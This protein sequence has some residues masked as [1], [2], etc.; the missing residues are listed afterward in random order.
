MNINFFN[1]KPEVEID[2]EEQ[3]RIKLLEIGLCL[4]E[5]RQNKQLTKEM[6]SNQIHVPIRLLEA[7]ESANL[8]ELP[9]PIYT[10]EL[11]R[12][13]AN[14][15]GLK[16]DD[17]ANDF[18]IE[19]H[20]NK[21]PKYYRKF[22]VNISLLKLN[23]FSLYLIYIILVFIS[24]KNLAN[25][26]KNSPSTNYNSNYNSNKIEIIEK[27]VISSKSSKNNSTPIAIPAVKN[28]LTDNIKTTKIKFEPEKIIIDVTAEDE[29]WIKITIDGKQEFKGTLKKGEQRK[30]T[31]NEKLTVRTGN[32]GGLLVMLNGEKTK[33][34]GKSGEVKEITFEKSSHS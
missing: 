20:R 16:G 32:A 19:V 26:V 14:S 29:C 31:A 24:V 9:E 7:I 28:P 15:L 1:K 2:F 4:Q 10:R 33:S 18:N 23:P 8:N 12:K 3:R 13:Y 21:S 6:I 30:W 5:F 11:L 17:L 22:N 25:F 34:L 27:K